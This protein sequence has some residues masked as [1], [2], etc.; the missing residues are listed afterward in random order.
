M[1]MFKKASKSVC[2]L[3]IVVSPDPLFPTPST[4]SAVKTEEDPVDPEP[5]DKGDIEMDT[6][7][8]SCAAQ[9]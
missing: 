1:E 4:S 2:T 5:A 7:L 6:P 8:I 9:L 3:G